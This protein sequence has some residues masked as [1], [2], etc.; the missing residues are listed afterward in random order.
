MSFP[1]FYHFNSTS[2]TLIVHRSHI[3][4]A[5][6]M[7]HLHAMLFVCQVKVKLSLCFNLAPHHE[8]VL[9]SRGIVVRILDL[10]ARW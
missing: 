8:G 3:C 2:S 7:G 1:A 9:G 6:Q 10:G 4:D 5:A